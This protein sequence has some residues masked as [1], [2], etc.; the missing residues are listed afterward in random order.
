MSEARRQIH[1]AELQ[2]THG[3]LARNQVLIREQQAR[4]D[5]LERAGG[6][7]SD[8]SRQLLDLLRLSRK[9]MEDHVTLL[10]RELERGE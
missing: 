8:V 6:R 3:H 5:R 1:L 10:E 7:V 2:I 4:M 9:T